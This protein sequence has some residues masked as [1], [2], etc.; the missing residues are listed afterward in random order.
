MGVAV[1]KGVAAESGVGN[2]RRLSLFLCARLPDVRR[3]QKK[4][5]KSE[6]GFAAE[7]DAGAKNSADLFDHTGAIETD[8]GG[9][10]PQSV[11]AFR[12]VRWRVCEVGVEKKPPAKRAFRG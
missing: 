10:P 4:L 5:S 1:V 8:G 7:P 2:E 9:K 12:L 11:T 3:L 6:G